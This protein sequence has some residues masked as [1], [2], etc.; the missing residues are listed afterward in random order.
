MEQCK[1][2]TMPIP[3]DVKFV[4]DRLES[5]GYRAYAV[6]GCVRDHL[7]GRTPGDYD[8]TTSASPDEM[9]RVFSDC[10]VVETGL[11]H[12]TLTIV[13]HG[14]NIETTT[15]R[16]DGSYADGRHPDAV[17]FT[18]SLA[19]DL[20]RRDFTINA[21]AYHPDRGIVDL[22]GGE[23]DLGARVIRCVGCAEERFR[24]DGL[25][26]LRALRFSSVLDFT[27]D[28]ECSRAI[29]Q[30]SYLLE[31]ISSERIYVELTKLLCGISAERILHAYSDV[32]AGLIYGLTQSDVEAAARY[33]GA[34]EEVYQRKA[35]AAIR[36]AILLDPLVGKS[37][38]ESVARAAMNSLKPSRDERQAV[39]SILRAR[40]NDLPSDEYGVLCLMR[41]FGDDFPLTLAR[42]LRAIGRC[43]EEEESKIIQ[44]HSEIIKKDCPRSLAQ[45]EIGGAELM[46]L[47]LRGREIGECMASLLDEVMRGDLQNEKNTLIER[48]KSRA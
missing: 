17:V 2:I 48:A 36:Y 34:D 45:L 19:E 6:G 20:C 30:L 23:A 32:I 15:Y 44:I 25:R 22:H 29:H 16:I 35:D 39:L 28:E 38:D 8:V 37:G 14:M 21:M 26:I 3:D 27:P 18:D 9:L 46:A 33:I 12:G 5:A 4:I 42:F 10:R 43:N 7:M 13:R 24:E 41:D 11:K 47:G 1:K 31:K 40:G